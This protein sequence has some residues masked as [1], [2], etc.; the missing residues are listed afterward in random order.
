MH[1]NGFV[2]PND[3][4][5]EPI[6]NIRNTYAIIDLI[7]GNPPFL[8]G[9]RILDELGKEYQQKLWSVYQGRVAGAADICVYWIEKAQQYIERHKN[10]RVGLLATQSIRGGINREVLAAIKQ[11]GD[12]FFAVSDRDWSLL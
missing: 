6:E 9:S 2:A 12:I 1:H 8:G 11:S 4:V 7:V 10:C 3:P 5:L